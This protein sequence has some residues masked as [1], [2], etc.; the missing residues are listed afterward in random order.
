MSQTLVTT[1]NGLSTGGRRHLLRSITVLF[2]AGSCFGQP[3]VSLSPTSGPPTR[4]VLVTGSGFAPNTAVDIYFQ[5]HDEAL[6]ITDNS[7][8]FS[9]IAIRTP[10]SALPGKY[11]VSAVQRST[12]TGA[13]APFQV[14]TNWAQS[15][16]SANHTGLN[17][18]ENVLN[19]SNVGNID[20]RWSYPFG[21][22][23]WT[24]PAVANGV[25]YVGS[26]SYVPYNLTVSALSA[27]TG[28]LLWNYI[29]GGQTYAPALA[30]GVAYVTSTDGSVNALNAGTG[31]LLWKYTTGGP[32]QYSATVASGVVYV[33]S[34]DGNV[35][36][37]S[38][39]TGTLQWSYNTRNLLPITS[40]AVAN[41]VVYF[42]SW[43]STLYALNA[44]TG[45]PLWVY[46]FGNNV[47]PS[48]AAVASGIVY[49]GASNGFIYALNAGTGALLWGY[50]VSGAGQFITSPAVANE[51]VYVGSQD[52]NIYALNAG[53]GAFLWNYT[54]YG[55]VYGSPVVA[56]GVVYVGSDDYNVYALNA[57]TGALLWLYP[58][59]STIYVSSPAVANGIVYVGSGDGNVYAFSQI[60]AAQQEAA[61]TPN[62]KQLR[63]DFSLKVSSPVTVLPD[64]DDGN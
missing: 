38:A 25:V 50:P 55:P 16:F 29:A 11:W 42:A 22:P 26:V 27:S 41:G 39:A 49:V 62:L 7:G 20:L 63:P 14:H 45:A 58:T 2:I 6:A 34:N 4:Y 24:S 32:I 52:G 47:I 23:V 48:S 64:A 61:P 35:Y 3:T 9:Q 59:G 51:V 36:A 33:G 53:T 44:G 8:S 13:Q 19:P 5:T 30:N 60:G 28:A 57:T 31:A 18:Y 56:N 1:R 15:Q 21:V 46:G 12:G 40:P 10:A 37:L 54:T 43:N 17:P